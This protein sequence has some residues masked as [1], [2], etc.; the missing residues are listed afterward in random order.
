MSKCTEVQGAAVNLRPEK[1][2][3]TYTSCYPFLQCHSV[4]THHLY[5]H[6]NHQATWWLLLPC[7]WPQ[8]HFLFSLC[9]YCFYFLLFLTKIM[10]FLQM[11]WPFIN[12]TNQLFLQPNIYWAA[13]MHNT[14]INKKQ[15]LVSKILIYERR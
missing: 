10:L 14:K 7:F 13:T 12:T 1:Y 2:S 3:I 8:L 6:S 9:L 15:I 4:C 11:N 5:H